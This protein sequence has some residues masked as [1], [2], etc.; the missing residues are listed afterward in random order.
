MSVKTPPRETFTI[1]RHLDGWAVQY[2]G[3]FVDQSPTQEEARAA[4]NRRAR[5]A[6][7]SGHACQVRVS[8]EAGFFAGA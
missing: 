8:G 3:E 4:A 6:Q 7:D 1:M 5:A 2:N